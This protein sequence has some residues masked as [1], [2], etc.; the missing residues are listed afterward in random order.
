[1][2]PSILGI[3]NMTA[4]SF[5]DG[6][7][8]LSPDDALAQAR[9]LHENGSDILDIGPAS[10]HPDSQPVSAETEIERLQSVVPQLLA[11]G[12]QISIDS[13]Q[14]KTQIWAAAQGVAWLNDIQGFADPQVQEALADYDCNLFIMH[15]IQS[16]GPAKREQAPAGDIWDAI[17]AF[18]DARLQALDKAGIARDRMVLD[19]GMGFFLG[20]TP[21]TSLQVL[22]QIKRLQD[23]YKL[24]VLISVSRKSFLRQLSHR[25]VD[26][27]GPVT[28]A[29]ELWAAAQGVEYIRTHD[30]RQL[31]DA[32]ALQARLDTI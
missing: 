1:M 11:Q 14:P 12:R 26:E 18:F 25:Q 5:S 9:Y 8:F 22:G 28:L 13:F 24:P 6:G 17:E 21:E 31:N 29:A 7:Q 27:S 23:N 20:D 32:L 3:L 16:A 19:P 2:R 4:D 15:S 30:P 10:S